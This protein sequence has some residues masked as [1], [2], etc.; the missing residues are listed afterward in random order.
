ML[1]QTSDPTCPGSA[2]LALNALMIKLVLHNNTFL[3]G[4]KL[5]NI[6]DILLK[7]YH[8]SSSLNTGMLW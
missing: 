1:I 5:R 6:D 7:Q 8:E 4:N 3:N 2:P